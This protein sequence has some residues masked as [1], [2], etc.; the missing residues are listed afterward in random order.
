LFFTNTQLSF[1]IERAF[2]QRLYFLYAYNVYRQIPTDRKRFRAD[3]TPS[4]MSTL[5]MICHGDLMSSY[6]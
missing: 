2:E 1:Y 3:S 6:L 5:E 4:T